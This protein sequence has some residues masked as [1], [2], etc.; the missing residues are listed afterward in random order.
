MAVKRIAACLVVTCL[1]LPVRARAAPG[2]CTVATDCIVPGARCDAQ[3][4]TIKT[5]TEVFPTLDL[6]EIAQIEPLDLAL[7]H[8][9]PSFRWTPPTNVDLIAIVVFT[10]PPQYADKPDVVSNFSDAIWAWDSRLPGGNVSLNAI[11]FD[12][13][14]TVKVEASNPIDDDALVAGPPKELRAGTYYWGIWAWNGV[15]L[16]ARSELHTFA[17][18]AESA[19]GRLCDPPNQMACDGPST[20]RCFDD[21]YCVLTCASDVDCFRGQSCDLGVVDK[22]QAGLCRTVV[23]PSCDTCPVSQTC[24][25]DLTVCHDQRLASAGCSTAYAS[26]WLALLAILFGWTHV[27]RRRG[28]RR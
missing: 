10:K 5:T 24:E 1:A 25:T 12:D 8:S 28:V 3:K 6:A 20:L 9:T 14:R 7:V 11:T 16:V 26:T 19:T 17:V 15:T 22:I 27:V 23:P 13:G 18:G 2:D 4:C 21:F